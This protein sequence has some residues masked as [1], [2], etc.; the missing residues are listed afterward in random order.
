MT[1]L[2]AEHHVHLIKFDEGTEYLQEVSFEGGDLK[3]TEYVNDE[4]DFGSSFTF[5]DKGRINLGREIK[6]FD[7]PTRMT[8]HHDARKMPD[9]MRNHGHYW[10]NDKVKAIIEALEPGRHQFFELEAWALVDGKPAFVEPMY[11]LNVC[12]LISAANRELTTVPAEKKGRY[13]NLAR[14]TGTKLE[15]VA[16]LSLIGDRHC[17]IER[18]TSRISGSLFI[19]D[20]ARAAFEDARVTGLVPHAFPAVGGV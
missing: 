18:N 5:F 13:Y 20:Q 12:N 6:P 3:S 19:S 17:W 7:I 4:P 11:K 14:T 15:Y 9:F 2:N 8:W 16:D 1:N 10:V